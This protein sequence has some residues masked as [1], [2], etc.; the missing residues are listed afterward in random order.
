MDGDMMCITYV[1]FVVCPDVDIVIIHDA[2]RPIVDEDCISAVIDAAFEHG[3]C[4]I[5]SVL[6]LL[7][8]VVQ[9]L[10]NKFL[11]IMYCFNQY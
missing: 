3:V 10:Q 11:F 5:C 1:W 2:V 6:S 4:I 9:K 7:L 8:R